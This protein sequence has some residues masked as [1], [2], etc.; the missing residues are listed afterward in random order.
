MIRSHVALGLALIGAVACG[1][2]EET[3]QPTIGHDGDRS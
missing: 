1:S 3:A 2:K